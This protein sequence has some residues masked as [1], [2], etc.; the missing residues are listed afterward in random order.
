MCAD[1]N[2]PRNRE[3]QSSGVQVSLASRKALVP[4]SKLKRFCLVS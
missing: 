2:D 3:R 1:Q 4:Q